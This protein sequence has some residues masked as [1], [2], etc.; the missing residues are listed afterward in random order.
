VFII[1]PI[2]GHSRPVGRFGRGLA[3]AMVLTAGAM[4]AVVLA[5]PLMALVSAV[6]H[7]TP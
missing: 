2:G 4:V 1:I 6:F 7:D 5:L 3:I